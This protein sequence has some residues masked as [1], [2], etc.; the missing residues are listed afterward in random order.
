MSEQRTAV[1]EMQTSRKSSRH[2]SL[3]RHSMPA[4]EIK[5][6]QAVAG[7]PN[8]CF[9]PLAS[10]KSQAATIPEVNLPC[11]NRRVRST[12]EKFESSQ[13]RS[14]AAS[15]GTSITFSPRLPARSQESAES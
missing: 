15:N 5:Q 12:R 2:P 4:P 1:D 6:F 13:F 3:G 11:L 14:S 7:A 10:I 9:Q 8:P